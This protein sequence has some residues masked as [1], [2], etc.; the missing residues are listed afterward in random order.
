MKYDRHTIHS[1]ALYLSWSLPKHYRVPNKLQI[2]FAI[3]GLYDDILPNDMVALLKDT[4]DIEYYS[5][6][7]YLAWSEDANKFIRLLRE[8]EVPDELFA[9]II[10]EEKPT[11]ILSFISNWIYDKVHSLWNTYEIKLCNDSIDFIIK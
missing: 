4:W 10:S 7:L 8:L 6:L 9:G 1:L 11:C 5:S 3:R 2:I